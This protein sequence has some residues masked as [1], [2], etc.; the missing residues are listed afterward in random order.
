MLT[1]AS[2]SICTLCCIAEEAGGE[3]TAS[4][5]PKVLEN[6]SSVKARYCSLEMPVPLYAALFACVFAELERPGCSMGFCKA[7]Q[8]ARNR[9]TQ[10][11]NAQVLCSPT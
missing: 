6:G 3:E 4:S 1:L 2:A 5:N 8:A 10:P 7:M 9:S 11:V